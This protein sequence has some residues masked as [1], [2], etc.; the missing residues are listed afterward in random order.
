[1]LSKKMDTRA[2]INFYLFFLFF[3][4]FGGVI[5]EKM[6]NPSY[7]RGITVIRRKK[8]FFFRGKKFTF[9][10]T[11]I[12]FFTKKRFMNI[13]FVT[14]IGSKKNSYRKTIKDLCFI[15]D[16]YDYH[17]T[18]DGDVYIKQEKL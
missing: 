11:V 5:L 14:V 16:N 15:F 1:M 7:F 13:F 8:N 2:K 6:Q 10:V 9:F 12:R 17:L 4:F 18:H 3:F